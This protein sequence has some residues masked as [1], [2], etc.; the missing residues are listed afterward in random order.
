[1]SH[2]LLLGQCPEADIP[3]VTNGVHDK[4]A[5]MA[6]NE[7]AT[8]TCDTGYGLQDANTNTQ[9]CVAGTF[10]GTLPV[11]IGKYHC[12]HACMLINPLNHSGLFIGQGLQTV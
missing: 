3:S 8:Y 2:F 6:E 5:A 12:A 7:V 10:V 11:C 1:M 4:T 9:T